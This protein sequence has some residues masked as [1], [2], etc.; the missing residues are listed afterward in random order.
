MLDAELRI[1]VM[2]IYDFF[3]GQT[4]NDKIIKVRIKKCNI[5]K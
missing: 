1:T 4:F 5:K 3:R 2:T